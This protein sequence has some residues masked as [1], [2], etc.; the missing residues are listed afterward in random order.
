MDLDARDIH[1]KQFHDA[2]RGYNQEQVDD[3]LDRVAE[4]LDRAQ[5]ENR[6]L[7]DRIT[8]LEELAARSR[9]AEEMLKKT[10]VNA[11]R[12]AEEAIETARS[13]A[14]KLVAEAEERARRQADD[15]MRKAE[16]SEREFETRRRELDDAITRLK[17]HES[18]L[19]QKLKG[20]LEDQLRMLDRLDSTSRRAEPSRPVPE[21]D[22]RP[23]PAGE[24]R[25]TPLRATPSRPVPDEA[26]GA[27]WR[28]G[29]P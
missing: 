2:W 26:E 1:T 28:R 15:A 7:R 5:R 8:E 11:Q 25:A 17:N 24:H 19:K 9:N 21:R 6:S 4:A 14:E 29:R 23:E 20:F 27:G 13:K 3:F 16:R 10:L 12:A 22:T 18:D